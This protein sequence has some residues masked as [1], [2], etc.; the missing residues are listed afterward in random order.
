MVHETGR[1]KNV[2]QRQID[3]PVKEKKSEN[4]ETSACTLR[5]SSTALIQN[6][7]LSDV[8]IRL[9][10]EAVSLEETK[11][12]GGEKNNISQQYDFIGPS[13]AVKDLFALP[14]SE[15]DVTVA[16]HNL[17][18]GTL[19]LDNGE[20][21]SLL[22]AQ[23][24]GQASRNAS[25]L[26]LSPALESS[27]ENT[28]SSILS[29]ALQQEPKLLTLPN[30]DPY[31][32]ASAMP[33]Q[34][35]KSEPPTQSQG[36]PRLH[37]NDTM[38]QT[39]ALAMPPSRQN[40]HWKF[41]D[42]NMLLSSDAVIYRPE[43][44]QSANESNAVTL[45]VA[46][47]SD[48]QQQLELYQQQQSK[49]VSYAQ[50]AAKN[51]N[52]LLDKKTNNST[53]N[54]SVNEDNSTLSISLP[55]TSRHMS[56]DQL[57]SCV[58]PS[59]FNS[60]GGT[61][62]SQGS[63]KRQSSSPVYTCLDAYLDNI[64]ASVPQLALCLAEKGF[65]QAVKLLRTEDIP[66]NMIHSSTLDMKSTTAPSAPPPKATTPMFNP[67]SV[68]VNATMLLRF[69]KQHCSSPNATY[70]LHRRA[71]D[72]SSTPAIHLYDITALSRQR[73]RQWI[74]WLAMMSYK[75]AL[76]LQTHLNP[77]NSYLTPA[78]QRDMRNRQRSLLS[79][80]LELLDEIADMDG[81]KHETICATINEHLADTYLWNRSKA[82]ESTDESSDDEDSSSLKPHYKLSLFMTAG[83]PYGDVHVNGLTKA[84]DYLIKAI[85]MLEPM[86]ESTNYLQSQACTTQLYHLHCKLVHV[87][88]RLT[89]H[90]FDKYWS[91]SVLQSI[92][93]SARHLTKSVNLLN[94]IF[95][96]TPKKKEECK[97]EQ[98]V[99]D[100]EPKRKSK[101]QQLI[102]NT[103]RHYQWIWEY[104]G[105]FAR[106]FTADPL[107][108][109][110]G[111]TSGDDVVGLL[112]DVEWE[113]RQ[114]NKCGAGST[115]SCKAQSQAQCDL[116]PWENITQTG[117]LSFSLTQAPHLTLFSLEA[118]IV[119]DTQAKEAAESYLRTLPLL[120][121]EKLRVLLAATV[122]YHKAKLQNQMG[123]TCNEVGKMLLA[124]ANDL[125]TSPPTN[126]TNNEDLIPSDCQKIVVKCLLQSAE[127][128]FRLGLASFE[129]CGH[130]LNCA[131]LRCNLSQCYKIRATCPILV[132]NG[133]ET[134]AENLLQTAAAYLQHAHIDLDER[135]SD[136]KI[137]DQVSE[138][139]AATFLVL[140]VHRRQFLIGSG[141][142]PVV[143]QALRLSPG[144]ERS[145]VHPMEQA[146]STY[147]ELGNSHQAAAVHYQLALYYAKIWTCQ[148]DE[149][150]TR[151]KLS[152]AF[153]H[154]SCAHQYFFNEMRS[155]EPTFV[156]LTLDLSNLYS[157]V[158]GP[159]CLSKAL[160]C[161]FDTIY[162]FSPEAIEAA[163][164][165]PKLKTEWFDKMKTLAVSVEER[166][167]SLLVSLVKIEKEEGGSKFKE[168]YRTALT[169]KMTSNKSK[170]N[171]SFG[172]ESAFDV[173]PLLLGV[174]E[175]Y[176][177]YFLVK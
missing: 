70:L 3:V 42:M 5:R 54:V 10:V 147:Q 175:C 47:I 74:W 78:V 17:G 132:E 129:H 143:A 2:A 170:S 33:Q 136:P 108:R 149:S 11:E 146:L 4:D 14:L 65:V 139:L 29:R 79:T 151:E 102:D 117:D 115:T 48:I 125:I 43:G 109:D 148:R 66:F 8:V 114:S 107:W 27:D 142:T 174:K 91:S 154:Y 157:T 127:L 24:D 172:D 100:K 89:G 159:D 71:G 99:V 110:R 118:L 38:A 96:Q 84:Q 22:S 20:Y 57:Q 105:H 16:L 112:Q 140:G 160:S 15:G 26:Q 135:D 169:T 153:R 156:I 130:A 73:Q 126:W 44:Y 28:A 34:H 116:L 173:Y 61:F 31:P 19:L 51:I 12:T 90:H 45:K 86:Q 60:E 138:E 23:P 39:S 49:N 152:C 97:L 95:A 124:S 55:M 171:T 69:L 59:T 46:N 111:H 75:F 176:D 53:A 87:S 92:R 64:M 93:M 40:L 80:S 101:R 88:L 104:C 94:E 63:T 162:A 67:T 119:A 41:H 37:D 35:C 68:D 120:K 21:A 122:C 1:N 123:D 134:I 131:L 62:F 6:K 168:M 121:R 50:I 30:T 9:P 76:S 98:D 145:I 83:L 72:D 13:S 167:L 36:L 81:M 82:D 106:S 165:R 85:K 177:K 161:C 56:Q 7:A 144:K 18:N 166:I 150:K 113:C 128:W 158:S 141:T 32:T 155:N 137:W 133:N 58:L 25:V 52:R 164:L 103:D 163:H 77:T